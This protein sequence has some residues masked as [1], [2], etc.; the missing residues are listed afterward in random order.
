[1]RALLIESAHG[2]AMV[3]ADL[4]QDFD[5]IAAIAVKTYREYWQATTP[6][7]RSADRFRVHL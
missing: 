3:R 1:M 5:N 6:I 4:A 7:S 2:A